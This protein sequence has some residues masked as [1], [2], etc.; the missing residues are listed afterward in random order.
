MSYSFYLTDKRQIDWG[1]LQ[2]RLQCF[3]TADVR[4]EGLLK[5]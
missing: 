1:L 4:E 5:A 2:C 3:M